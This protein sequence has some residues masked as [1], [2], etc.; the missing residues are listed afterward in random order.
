[1]PSISSAQQRPRLREDLFRYGPECLSTLDLLAIV[2][3]TGTHKLGV[4]ELSLT[5]LGERGLDS[6]CFRDPTE[7]RARLGVGDAKAAR[8]LAALELGARAAREAVERTSI[9]SVE[10]VERWALP[11]LARLEHEELWL[12]CLDVK[13]RLLAE[14]EV[15]RGG[16]LGCSLSPADVLRPAV[17]HGAA[18]IV[19]VHNHPSGDPTPSRDDM[20]MTRA[21][22]RACRVVGIPLLDHVVVARGGACSA[23][24]DG[25]PEE[26]K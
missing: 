18:A 14:V 3:G 20:L 6:T 7:L 8:V 25:E 9:A 17:R 10:D 16:A 22:G 5:L 23:L 12:L 15:A 2:L 24:G 13:N 19:I 11:R 21:L 26:H 1:M 4:R